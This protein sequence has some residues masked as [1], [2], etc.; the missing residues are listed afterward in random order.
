MLPKITR[1]FIL[2][3]FFSVATAFGQK[4]NL[5]VEGTVVD[6]AAA[7][8][9]G[10][11]VVLLQGVDSVLVSFGI[12]N[13][14]GLFQIKRVAPGDYI[15]QITF[16]GYTPVSK[17][18]TV[19]ATNIQLGSV[20][21]EPASA[22]LAEVVV[23]SEHI[24]LSI[25]KDTLEYNADAF[26]TQPNAVVEDLLK[27]LPGVE[28]A[29]DGSI[30]A[31]GKEVENVLVDGKEFFG[32]DPQVATKNLPANAV[33]KVQ[34][35]DKKS[36]TAEF[37]GVDDGQKEK[38]INLQLKPD[39]K[40]GAFGTIKGGYGTDERFRG[41]VN[42]N[43]FNPKSQFSILG[44]GNNINEQGFN[45]NDY[46]NFMGGMQ[47]MMSG[48]GGA[49]R[50]QLS[51]DSDIPL[52]VFGGNSGIATS[53]AGGLNWN[54]E[55]SKKTEVNAS[56]FYNRI[57]N[58][59]NR[60]IFK[61]NWLDNDIFTTDENRDLS[62]R[63]ENHRLNFG[64]KSDLD[65]VSQIHF[66]TSLSFN[67]GNSSSLSNTKSFR[68]SDLPTNEGFQDWRSA[69]DQ[70]NLNSSLV[71]RRRFKKKGRAFVADLGFGINRLDRQGNLLAENRFL[72]QTADTIRQRQLTE[73]NGGNYSVSLSYTEPVGRGKFLEANV[74]RQNYNNDYNKK[75]YDIL[76]EATQS[77][78]LNET[79]SDQFR[80]DYTYDRAGLRFRYNKKSFNFNTSM[81]LQK[82]SL[83]GRLASLE[84]PISKDFWNLMPGMNMEYE[85]S[86][87]KSLRF[88]YNTNIQ[89]PSLEQLQP[90]EDNSD[91][92][93]IYVGNPDL[94]PTYMHQGN[95][96][97][98]LFDQFSQVNFFASMEGSYLNNPITNSQT[99]DTLLRQRIQPVNLDHA[100]SWGGYISFGAPLRFIN[101]RF[102]I[103]GDW[104]NS[105]SFFLLNGD[106]NQT[107]QWTSGI[108]ISLENKNK[109]VVDLS[110]GVKI[111]Y[112]WTGYKNNSDLNQDFS[113]QVYF[114]DIT[115]IPAK[116]WSIGTSMDYTVYSKESFGS[117][118]AIP[119][120]RA[121]VSKFLFNNRGQLELAAFD[122]LNKNLGIRRSGTLNSFYEERTVSLGRYFMV[123]FTWAL[124]GSVN[125]S[126]GGIEIRSVR[127]H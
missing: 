75:F 111:N 43:R 73:D 11:T 81:H 55:L 66:R 35:Y 124:S 118:Q 38:T 68:N 57:Q 122:L 105:R 100:T 4:S 52:D 47:R 121:S 110:G 36:D 46:M 21:M 87:G 80:R 7:P 92:L 1:L 31:M 59:Q 12:T 60:S 53:L 72:G 83:G 91:P 14:A 2:F 120:W 41:K 108:E 117:N 102:T 3:F 107:D 101:S 51:S 27:K 115:V 89:A 32:R 63:N 22:N 50:L 106:Q 49:F 30:K 76:D 97:F 127:G 104:R 85:F 23:K 98:F 77:E 56:Y 67:D 19:E 8:L 65:S 96:H 88:D 116:S 103:A 62:S 112:D 25:R 42:I 71:Y 86:A 113:N 79:L 93:N 109:D 54:Y 6:S 125:Q 70:V 90:I 17:N 28:V 95:L 15:L 99:I 24:P 10:A 94:R 45:I 40:K 119:I 13:D 69:G 58:D 114:A 34:V 20:I 39:K 82:S 37:T 48:G 78:L 33:D 61:Q 74:S 126:S 44:M 5:L 84:S 64:I 123:N 9:A 18:L 26:K 16:V 29:R